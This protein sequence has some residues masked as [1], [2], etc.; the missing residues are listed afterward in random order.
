MAKSNTTVSVYIILLHS[1]F[2]GFLVWSH[3]L[4]LMN[5]FA[6]NM[7][8]R[9]L[10]YVVLETFSAYPG[11]VD[12]GHILVLVLVFMRDFKTD[13]HTGQADLYSCQ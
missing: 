5:T 13:F 7:G 12:L 10:C 4:T 6:V 2:D 9:C 1:L 8:A 3:G 11:V